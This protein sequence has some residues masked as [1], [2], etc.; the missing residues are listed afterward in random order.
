MHNLTDIQL[1]SQLSASNLQDI[2]QHAVIKSYVKDSII[3]YEGDSAQYLYIVLEGTVKLYK[4]TPKGTQIQI[5]RIEAPATVGEYACFENAPFPA[6]CEFVTDGTVAMIHFDY[7]FKN[8]ENKQFSL[9]STLFS[10]LINIRNNY[11]LGQLKT[12]L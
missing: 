6:S 9:I 3:F 5:N 10:K 1:F 4:T 11:Q 12:L 2:Q 7:V 8:L